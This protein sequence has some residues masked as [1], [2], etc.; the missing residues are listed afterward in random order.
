MF[1]AAALLLAVAQPLYAADPY[2]VKATD[3]A[4]PKEVQDP[5]RK[6][7]ADK[8][9]QVSNAKGDVVLELWF[10]KELPAKATEAQIKNGLTYREVAETTVFGVAKVETAITDYRKQ[11]IK[12]GVYTL[13][14]AIQP[15]DGDHMGTAQYAEFLLV[16]PAADD[17]KADT[18]EAKALQE[19]SAKS[20]GAH[21]GVFMLFPGKDAGDEPKLVNK[22]EGH[23]VLLF[24]EPIAAG[25]K[26][27]TMQI[28]LTLFG[29]SPAAQ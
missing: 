27:G 4:P 15:M 28:G 24:K 12:P 6:L 14:L 23:W 19:M 22:G 11:A 7:L 26:K 29:A 9:V 20:T 25:D 16:S 1:G 17:K 13:R 3:A 18:M 21:P 5:I 2:A 10:R 8:G